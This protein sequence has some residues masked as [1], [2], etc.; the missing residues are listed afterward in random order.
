MGSITATGSVIAY[1]KLSG[2]LD[3][4]A[5]ALPGRDYINMGLV[6]LYTVYFSAVHRTYVQNLVYIVRA[7]RSLLQTK[8]QCSL[9]GLCVSYLM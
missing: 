9:Q 1:G 8:G 7:R 5:L 2:S 3:S 6:R 4:A